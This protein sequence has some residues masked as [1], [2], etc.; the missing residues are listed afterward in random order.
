MA[1]HGDTNNSLSKHLGITPLTMSLKI[2]GK[3]A[4]F[5][6]GEIMSIAKKYDLTADQIN[7]I[8][9]AEKVS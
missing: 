7:Q 1:L 9:F 4:E 3:G 8:F 6:Q 5:T 2:N